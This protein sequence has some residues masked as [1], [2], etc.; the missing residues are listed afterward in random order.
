MFKSCSRCGL[1]HPFNKTCKAGGAKKYYKYNSKE[2]MI[3]NNRK[4]F[5]ASA[6]VKE[7]SNY[8][9]VVCYLNGVFNSVNTETHHIE[10][11]KDRPD[12]AYDIDNLVCLCKVHHMLAD[13]GLIDKE[14]IKKMK[15]YFLS[16]KASPL[17]SCF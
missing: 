1:I 8:L 17:S 4:Y 6:A 11:I 10:K 15:E 9:C 5:V 2:S 16:C 7:D 12:L 14:E 13:K 3:R